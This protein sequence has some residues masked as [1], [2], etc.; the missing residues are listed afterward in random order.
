MTL[1]DETLNLHVCSHY[2]RQQ[3]FSFENKI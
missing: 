3:H 1:A 2:T